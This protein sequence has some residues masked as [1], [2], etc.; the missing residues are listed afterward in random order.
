MLREIK[1][2]EIQQEMSHNHFEWNTRSTAT[3]RI[4]ILIRNPLSSRLDWFI[5]GLWFAIT[6]FLTSSRKKLS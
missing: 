5:Y 3:Q 1:Q 4:G 6:S 2:Q